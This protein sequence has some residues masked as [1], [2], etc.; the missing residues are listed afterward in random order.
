MKH[1]KNKAR[2][3]GA[4][5][6]LAI[7]LAGFSRGFLRGTLFIPVGAKLPWRALLHQKAFFT[8]G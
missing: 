7:I 6:L 4:L 5:Y 2:W 1:L 3:I 8:W